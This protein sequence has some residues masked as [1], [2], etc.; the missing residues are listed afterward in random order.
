MASVELDPA[1][2][3]EQFKA[4]AVNFIAHFLI[5]GCRLNSALRRMFRPTRWQLLPR[6][7]PAILRALNAPGRESTARLNGGLA[8]SAG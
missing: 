7:T 1:A 5:R 2:F 4:I 6:F 3:N 8:W